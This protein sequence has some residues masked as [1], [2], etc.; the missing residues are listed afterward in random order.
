MSS[1]GSDGDAG[2]SR[3]IASIVHRESERGDAQMTSNNAG[4]ALSGSRRLLLAALVGVAMAVSACG[5]GEPGTST[6]TALESTT[7]S[8][9]STSSTSST[10]TT[11]LPGE[12]IDLGFPKAGDVLGVVG[13]AFDDMLNVRALPGVDAAVVAT[14]EPLAD[15]VVALGRSRQLPG[16]IWVEVQA[17]GATGWVNSSFV[18]YLGI[19]DDVTSQVIGQVGEIPAAETM[20]ML[21]QMV[22]EIVA[23]EEPPSEIVMVVAPSLGDLGEVTYDV[24]GLGDDAVRGLRLHVFGEPSQDG[25]SFTLKSIES[26]TLCGRGVTE[27]GFCI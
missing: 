11:S 24:I 12:P 1:T 18:A 6:S 23:S 25:K 2:S 27:D 13:V 14:L 3:W 4:A 20:A 21:G 22:A 7:T 16:S 19:V 15:E 8:V 10:T 17:D 9:T 5:G 26:T